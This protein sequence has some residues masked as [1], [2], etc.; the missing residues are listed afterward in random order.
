MQLE[1]AWKGNVTPMSRCEP[2]TLGSWEGQQMELVG[3]KEA[4]TALLPLTNSAEQRGELCFGLP[5]MRQSMSGDFDF[6]QYWCVLERLSC[7][8]QTPAEHTDPSKASL[9]NSSEHVWTA[10]R[11]T[12]INRLMR[13]EGLIL[14][15]L[16]GAWGQNG[17][18]QPKSE[19]PAASVCLHN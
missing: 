18:L 4:G 5:G 10:G 3:D 2:L 17:V 9:Q 19:R 12:L 14:E 11:H 7:G 15:Q 16:L 6:S 8:L 1:L 13:S